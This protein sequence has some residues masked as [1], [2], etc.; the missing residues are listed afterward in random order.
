MKY[1]N[2][3][4]SIILSYIACQASC[5]E[6]STNSGWKRFDGKYISLRLPLKTYSG[7]I[8]SLPDEKQSPISAIELKNKLT[9]ISISLK[10][11]KLTG[12]TFADIGSVCNNSIYVCAQSTGIK[13]Y[14]VDQTTKNI[15]LGEPTSNVYK[16]RLGIWTAYEAFPLCGWT[17][18]RGIYTPYGGQCYTVVLGSENKTIDFQIL[19]GQNKACVKIE[20]CWKNSLI[21]IRDIMRSVK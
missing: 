18:V 10:K 12:E 4:I 3:V 6:N 16:R 11:K 2:L 21:S 15:N 9:F 7:I 14:W 20:K 5:A 17:S 19:L 13:N 8:E 1:K